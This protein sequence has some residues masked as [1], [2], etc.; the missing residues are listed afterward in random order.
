MVFN[1]EELKALFQA[2][3]KTKDELLK[4]KGFGQKKIE[5]YGDAILRIINK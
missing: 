3:P 2:M 4:V 5:N 1:N